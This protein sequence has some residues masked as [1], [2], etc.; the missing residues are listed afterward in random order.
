MTKISFHIYLYFLLIMLDYSV[1]AQNTTLPVGTVPG[2]AGVSSL[3]AATYSIPIEVVPGTHGVQPE[4]SVVYNSMTRC[5]ILGEKCDLIGM[6][7]ISRVGKTQFLDHSVSP[8]SFTYNDRFSLDGNRL[9]C[10][11]P[12]QYGLSGTTYYPEFEDFS[13]IVSYGTVAN[14]PEHFKVLKQDGAVVEYGNSED[15]RQTTAEGVLNWHVSRY[16]DIHGNYT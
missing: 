10:M 16:T 12:T 5:G 2:N 4:L 9:V 6:S 14:G 11:D 7:C 1:F 13:T 3:G 15:S 8:V